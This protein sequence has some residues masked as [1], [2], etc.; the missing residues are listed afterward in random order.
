[1]SNI[2]ARFPHGTNERLVFIQQRVEMPHQFVE[3]I[4]RFSDRHASIECPGAY[5]GSRGRNNLAHRLHG[6]M[7]EE[8]T[9]DE[10]EQQRGAPADKKAA[11]DWIQHRLTT[12]G[13]AP[14]LQN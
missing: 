10:T 1:M 9:R 8:R 4:V 3:L 12:V 6:P 14:D 11:A 5:D 2:V 13:R 7:S